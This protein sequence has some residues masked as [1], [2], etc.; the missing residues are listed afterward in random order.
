[1]VLQVVKPPLWELVSFVR[2]VT[3]ARVVIELRLLAQLVT[4][5]Q[6]V[7]NLPPNTHAQ[8]LLIDQLPVP[9]HTPTALHAQA[10]V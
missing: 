8:S 6:R 9:L 7:Q 4:F 1:M 3:I 5:V 2:L 10:S